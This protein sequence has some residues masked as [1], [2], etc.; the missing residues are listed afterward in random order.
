MKFINLSRVLRYFFIK[1]EHSKDITSSMQE[2]T[3]AY[4]SLQVVEV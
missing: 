2:K 3:H 1:V 4:V